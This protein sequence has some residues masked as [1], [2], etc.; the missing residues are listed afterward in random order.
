MGAWVQPLFAK[1]N[2]SV[3]RVPKLGKVWETDF[4]GLGSEESGAWNKLRCVE[5]WA[6]RSTV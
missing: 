3:W 2:W 4:G 6:I 5:N 1:L